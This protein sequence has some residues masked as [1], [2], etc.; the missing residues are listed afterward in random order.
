MARAIDEATLGAAYQ[1]SERQEKSE[2]FRN[3]TCATSGWLPAPCL[4]VRLSEK[5]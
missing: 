1:R 2:A 3:I 5:P 4:P